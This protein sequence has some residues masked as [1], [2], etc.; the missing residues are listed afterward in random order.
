MVLS[1][2]LAM[3]AVAAFLWT[4][5]VGSIVTPYGSALNELPGLILILGSFL[6]GGGARLLWRAGYGSRWP[7][8]DP[9]LA[10]ASMLTVLWYSGMTLMVTWVALRI[11]GAISPLISESGL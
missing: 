6:V 10:L 1:F 3:G 5:F 11:T 8:G 7:Q 9:A 2:A 4:G